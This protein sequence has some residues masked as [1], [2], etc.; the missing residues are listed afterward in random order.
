MSHIIDRFF[1]EL[2]Q[3]TCK[4]NEFE[5]GNTHRKNITCMFCIEGRCH[6][7]GECDRRSG[8]QEH[9]GWKYN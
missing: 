9:E 2:D 4:D 6:Y 3:G 7:S 8:E 5:F 1:V